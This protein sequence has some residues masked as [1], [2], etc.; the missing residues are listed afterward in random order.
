[1]SLK[2]GYA[3]RSFFFTE[4]FRILEFYYW[5]VLICVN[6]KSDDNI[7][8]LYYSLHWI[9]KIRELVVKFIRINSSLFSFIKATS[10]K[11]FGSQ[12]V[13]WDVLYSLRDMKIKFE[14]LRAHF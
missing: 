8:L 7:Q 10:L 11:N 4:A 6:R 9:E 2:L 12:G 1:M 14:K 5:P 3:F 13:D